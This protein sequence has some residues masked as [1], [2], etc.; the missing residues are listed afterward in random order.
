[1]AQILHLAIQ[2]S[3][4]RQLLPS[5]SDKDDHHWNDFKNNGISLL[6]KKS[7]ANITLSFQHK[8]PAQHEVVPKTVTGTILAQHRNDPELAKVPETQAT[9]TSNFPRMVPLTRMLLERMAK[10]QFVLRKLYESTM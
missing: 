4:F 2:S 9:H 6:T 8:F 10:I 5:P 7:S 3:T 1:M